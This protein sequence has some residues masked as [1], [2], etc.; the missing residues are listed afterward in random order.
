MR[1]RWIIV[2]FNTGE[3]FDRSTF[4]PRLDEKVVLFWKNPEFEGR[5]I[6]VADE[7]YYRKNILPRLRRTV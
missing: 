6:V 2:D 5:A 1:K 7:N 3:I 4:K